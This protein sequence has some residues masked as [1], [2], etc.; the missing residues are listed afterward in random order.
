V[1]NSVVYVLG[2]HW[3]WNAGTSRCLDVQ[4]SQFWHNNWPASMIDKPSLNQSTSIKWRTIRLTLLAHSPV[5][6]A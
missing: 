6:S 5:K 1:V 3:W 4:H 2:I